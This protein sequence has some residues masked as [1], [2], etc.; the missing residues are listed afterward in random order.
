MCIRDRWDG[1]LETLQRL[2]PSE[3]WRLLPRPDVDGDVE[4]ASTWLAQQFAACPHDVRG[5]YLGLDTLN[6]ALGSNV[7]IG[8]SATADVGS[9]E[10]EWTFDRNIWRGES[11]LI[12]S[13][14]SMKRAYGRRAWRDVTPDPDYT[15]F[16]GYSGVVLAAAVERASVGHDLIAAW[17]FHDGDMF[18]LG[19][20]MPSAFELVV[21]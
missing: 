21:R 2:S 1:V 17:G 9:D 7:E 20:R 13:L 19:R 18:V 16:L 8:I 6:M 5:V 15:V 14:R 10:I 4:R 12:A 3:A 11:H